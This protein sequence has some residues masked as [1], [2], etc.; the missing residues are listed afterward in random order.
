[1]VRMADPAYM[2]IPECHDFATH[3]SFPNVLRAANCNGFKAIRSTCSVFYCLEDQAANG[4]NTGVSITG[5][6]DE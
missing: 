3:Q 6:Y 5:E 2:A 4:H 1:M